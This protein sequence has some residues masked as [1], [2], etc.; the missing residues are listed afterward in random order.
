[1]ELSILNVYSQGTLYIC[2]VREEGHE[3]YTKDSVVCRKN[4]NHQTNF[5]N[6]APSNLTFY[7]YE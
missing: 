5:T 2:I 3:Y 7:H 4:A 6:F 1:M